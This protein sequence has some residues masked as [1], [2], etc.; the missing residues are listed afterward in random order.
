MVET[1]PGYTAMFNTADDYHEL[2][3]GAHRK[4]PKV[5]SAPS[6][7]WHL[8]F[9]T[10][11]QEL[12]RGQRP[13]V[14]PEW[15]PNKRPDEISAALDSFI[16]E[17]WVRLEAKLG[18]TVD[19]TPRI[20]GVN[21]LFGSAYWTP[22]GDDVKKQLTRRQNDIF[23]STNRVVSLQ[24]VWQVLDV[25]I[26]FEIQAE[27]FTMSVFVELDRPRTRTPS[28]IAGLNVTMDRITA[29]L[30]PDR[31]RSAGS[32]SATPPSQE[33]IDQLAKDINRYSFHEFW[34]VFDEQVLSLGGQFRND[35]IFQ[36]VCAD[37]RG[38]IASERAVT[39]QD[40]RFFKFNGPPSWGAEAKQMLLPL[41]QHRIRTDHTRYE[42]AAN[43]MLDGRALYLSTL[44]PQLP[45][46][47][48]GERV[49]VEFIVYA[50][51]RVD[52]RTV[53]NKWQLG[54]LVSQIL[55]LGTFR[56]CALKDVKWLHNAGLELADLEE[57]TQRARRAIA[58]TEAYGT[59]PGESVPGTA[60]QRNRIAM[61]EIAKA[62]AQLNEITGKFLEQTGSGPLYRI[63]R[64]RYYVRQFEDNVKLLR[65]L[66]LEGDQP[67]D[68][69]IRRRLGP[70]FDFIDRLG[71]RYERAMSSIV[72]LDQNYLSITQNSLVERATKIDEETKTIQSEIGG[73]QRWGEFILLA[74][75]VPYYVSHMLFLIMGE[76]WP[77]KSR[78]ATGVWLLSVAFAIY[79][80]FNQTFDRRRLILILLPF[81]LAEL[82]LIG[83]TLIAP[84]QPGHHRAE[85]GM[86]DGVRTRPSHESAP[87]KSEVPTAPDEPRTPQ[88]PSLQSADP[89]PP[90]PA[91]PPSE[92]QATP[93][94]QP[95]AEP[96]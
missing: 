88:R 92:P 70:E 80:A 13:P 45:E 39:F 78:A 19:V 71:V 83:V 6:L 77:F 37:F 94:P 25:T 3:A 29:Y 12:G 58:Q 74:A 16:R 66:R 28:G 87:T 35:A 48:D 4:P 27:Y 8:A 54:R 18:T 17:L 62:H 67:Y 82:V 14:N 72:S 85:P 24:F 68:Q 34:R 91:R 23:A 90:E 76:E 49:P 44:G 11:F 51:Q 57:A 56:L 69:F 2:N 93:Q 15:A 32:D 46:I 59:R 40:D 79:R 89:S 47:P 53:V 1:V 86:D 60:N 50:H 96:R 61:A 10:N 65:I 81:A 7:V 20:G 26:R 55:Q 31:D 75:L 41:I 9:W 36:R 42:C 30:D 84:P 38:L 63:E 95:S 21:L 22:Q 33:V 64:S 43:Y 5:L 73:I 52:D